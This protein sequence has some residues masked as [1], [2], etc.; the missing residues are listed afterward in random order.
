MS[1]IDCFLEEAILEDMLS[2]LPKIRV[3]DVC[4]SR[5]SEPLAGPER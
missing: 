4:V 3:M 2:D 5:S 1:S